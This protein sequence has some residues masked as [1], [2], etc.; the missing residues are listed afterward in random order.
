MLGRV[1]GYRPAN[2]E[3][4]QPNVVHTVQMICVLMREEYGMHDPN[5]LAQQLCS[6]IRCGVDQEISTGQTKNGTAPGSVVARIGAGAN[7]AAASDCWNTDA[8][9]R[10]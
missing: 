2:H 3:R 8:R 10:S 5:P 6:Q 1:D 4:E 9:P 7:V